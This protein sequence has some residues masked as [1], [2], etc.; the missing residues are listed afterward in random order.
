MKRFSMIRIVAGAAIAATILM[1]QSCGTSD[2][3]STA[4]DAASSPANYSNAPIT[5]AMIDAAIAKLDGIAEEVMMRSLVP[6]MAIAVVHNDVMIFAKGY[7]VRS[8]TAPDPVDIHTVFQLA[9]LSKSVGATVVAGV[10]GDGSVSWDDPVVK[11]LPGFTLDDPYVT[12][13]VTISDLYSH[14]SGLPTHAGDLLEDLGYDRDTVLSRLNGYPLETFRTYER[15]T[16]FGL[17][18]AA[19]A[20]ATA[21]GTT[22]AALSKS[23]LYARIGM[24]D[25]SSTFADFMARENKALG[26]IRKDGVWELTPQQRDPDPQS[27]AGGV[28]ASVSDMANWMRLMLGAGSFEGDTVIDPQSLFAA[29]MPH[30]S[31]ETDLSRL[32]TTGL[33]DGRPGMYA[34]GIGVGVDASGRVRYSHSGAFLLGAATR[35]ELLP[36]EHLGIVV[37]TNGQ[38]RGIPEAVSA[39]FMD[40]VERGS[41]AFDWLSAYE[42]LFDN[43]YTN[44]SKLAGETPPVDPVPALPYAEY[45]GTYANTLYGPAEIVVESNG[46]LTMALGPVPLHFT[47]SHWSGNTFSYMPT[48]ENAVGISA[49]DFNATGGVV[50]AMTVEFLDENGLG[51]FVK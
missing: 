18:A 3:S 20:V 14:R 25:T 44:H 41:Q 45:A 35:Y 30:A 42:G 22:W 28:S 51:T 39:A 26:H 38:P 47:L 49:V 36:S 48:G 40:E 46:S 32:P 11:H 29:L 1:L 33:P 10:V 31:A 50:T 6:G 15:Y 16:N 12:Q 34:L 43:F 4:P 13:H 19:E 37:L 9:S 21:E 17:T 8:L 5:Q 2:T 7:G 23:R 24:N 27:P